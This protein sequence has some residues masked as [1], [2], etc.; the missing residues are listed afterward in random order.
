MIAASHS[1]GDSGALWPFHSRR[2]HWRVP[3]HLRPRAARPRALPERPPQSEPGC[4][5]SESVAGRRGTDEIMSFDDEEV[6]GGGEGTRKARWALRR[7]RTVRKVL[8][9]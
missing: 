2:C 6:A 4:W 7:Q 1:P 3:P 8:H 5:F 9:E